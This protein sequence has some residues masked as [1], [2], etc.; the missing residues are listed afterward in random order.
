MIEIGV[1]RGNGNRLN[2]TVIKGDWNNRKNE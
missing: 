1:M 2:R